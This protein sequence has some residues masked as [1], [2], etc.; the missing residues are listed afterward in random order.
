MGEKE[1]RRLKFPCR[2]ETSNKTAEHEPIF[3]FILPPSICA[4]DIIKEPL[5]AGRRRRSCRR[6]TY[7]CRLLLNKTR[8]FFILRL[9]IHFPALGVNVYKKCTTYNHHGLSSYTQKCYITRRPRII[10]RVSRLPAQSRHASVFDGRAAD[11]CMDALWM[12]DGSCCEHLCISLLT[13]KTNARIF[14]SW[15]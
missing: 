8:L 1:R 15:L 14:A 2:F 9:S 10:F 6:G 12:T 5:S 3:S 11:G 7:S 4:S 13:S